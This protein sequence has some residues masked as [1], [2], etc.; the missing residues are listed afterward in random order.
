M[1]A[2]NS[3]RDRFAKISLL[4]ILTIWIATA[5]QAVPVPATGGDEAWYEDLDGSWHSGYIFD[6]QESW[7]AIDV[8]TMTTGPLGVSFKWMTSSEAGWDWLTL[9]VDDKP[10]GRISGLHENWVD[11]SFILAESGTHTI[12]WVYTKDS[13][14]S[15]GDDCAWVKDFATAS[16]VTRPLTLNPNGGQVEKTELPVANGYGLGPL[17]TPVRSNYRFLG[18]FTAATGGDAVTAETV[19]LAGMTTIFAHW[20]ELNPPSN[21]NFANATTI[22][23]ANGSVRGTTYD[24]SREA[25]DLIPDMYDSEY[26]STVWYRWVAPTNG[27]YTFSATDADNPLSQGYAIGV[28]GGYDSINGEWTDPDVEWDSIEVVAKANSEFWISL[29]SW[30]IDEGNKTE[31]NFILS[32]RRHTPPS[33]DDYANA[34][35]IS[36]ASGSIDGT[37]HDA[38]SEEDDLIPDCYDSDYV[39]TVWYKWTAPADGTFVFSA[40]G[41][42]LGTTTGYDSE[43]GEWTDEDTSRDSITIYATTRKV[44]WISVGTPS[45]T[46]AGAFT[47]SWNELVKPANDDFADA[48]VISGASGST[49]GS[50]LGATIESDDEPYGGQEDYGSVW[51]KWVAPASGTATFSTQG[52]SFDTYL[53]VY[54]V[55][56]SE[57]PAGVDN[58]TEDASDD[59][60]FN[61]ATSYVEFDVIKDTVYWISVSGFGTGDIVLS[62]TSSASA[63]AGV[64]IADDKGTVEAV[65]NGYVVTAN[66]GETIEDGDIEV[67][68]ML[69]GILVDVTDGY[70]IV[71]AANGSSA[72]INL[73]APTVGI[74]T[75]EMASA[76]E[77]ND[78]SGF[79][80]SVDS[81]EATYGNNAVKAKPTAGAGE[82]VGA[83]PVKDAVPGLYYQASW[84]DSPSPAGMT[85]GEKVQA[86]NTVLFLGVIL[87]TGARGFYKL[88]VSEE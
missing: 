23:G 45:G 52:S 32:W 63:S 25:N 36:G 50:N 87:Q 66:A 31:S 21:D 3:Q 11:Y 10:T 4:T 30:Y 17:P 56:D 9:Y 40:P 57:K 73:M 68:A 8:D 69:D 42:A 22:S 5:G 83:L 70:T 1:N 64:S 79:L 38:S 88:T 39:S 16:V 72:T 18:W 13:S 60:S 65:G 59:D 80:L 67:W 24:S 82:S 28:T 26:P 34:V 41:C 46:D 62:W 47:L 12:R 54:E 84:G 20:K 76:A 74:S 75:G 29:G 2:A 6:G 14:G 48:T 27:T 55:D 35:S 78:K 86:D 85:T 51:W 7:M 43:N 61:D 44:Y 19:A 77:S 58:L 15:N 71:I 33:N 37:T 53:A 81:V 49:T